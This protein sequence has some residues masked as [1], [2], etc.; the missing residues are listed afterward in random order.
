MARKSAKAPKGKNAAPPDDM[1]GETPG[2]AD[3]FRVNFNS[4]TALLHESRRRR[5]R[6][7]TWAFIVIG[8]FCMLS[9]LTSFTGSS[10]VDIEPPSSTEVNMS[11]GKSAAQT[12]VQQWLS[13]TPTPL[14]GGYIVSWDGFELI[15]GFI[16]GE[17]E[18][19]I[20][21][22]AELHHFTLA[23]AI[24]SN[25]SYFD[26]SILVQVDDALG[27]FVASQPS[28]TP[29]LP[30]ADTG[31]SDVAWPGYR[32]TSVP[33]PV[34]QSVAQWAKAYTESPEALRLYVGDEDGTHSYM[35]LPGAT[36]VSTNVVDAG[37]IYDPSTEVISSMLIR[38]E[39]YVSWTGD[40]Q[41]GAPITF[42]ALV[43]QA[44]TASPKVVAWGHAGTGPDLEK[45]DN[46]IEGTQLVTDNLVPTPE[47]METADEDIAE[48]D[49]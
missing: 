6:G 26:V 34:E 20:A 4:P 27:A 40:G 45:F 32:N 13:S 16:E 23:T 44:H 1:F 9:Q 5:Q 3:V 2:D 8:S 28:M 38:V 21:D 33:E 37:Y 15:D 24:E 22:D 29:R 42:D 14:P 18:D 25:V 39:L 47:P 43:E 11:L 49:H 36:V 7:L 12:Y 17:D 48:G 19:A 41:P 46:A 31:W 35:P 10:E 30:S